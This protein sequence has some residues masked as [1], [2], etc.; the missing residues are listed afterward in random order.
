MEN[1]Y[2]YLQG[3][4]LQLQETLTKFASGNATT[5][6]LQLDLDSM[7]QLLECQSHEEILN[8]LEI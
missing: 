4:I 5:K 8:Y 7:S 3:S 2:L 6:E 1:N